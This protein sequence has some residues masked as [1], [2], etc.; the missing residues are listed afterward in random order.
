MSSHFRAGICCG[1]FAGQLVEAQSFLC[2]SLTPASANRVARQLLVPTLYFYDWHLPAWSLDLYS[3]VVTLL[4]AGESSLLYLPEVPDV[5]ALHIFM[6]GVLSYAQD[7]YG[8]L[9]VPSNLKSLQH[10][11]LRLLVASSWLP[12]TSRPHLWSPLLSMRTS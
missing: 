12:S 3:E 2:M 11:I 6:R 9:Q 4:T 7:W 5:R 8:N 1:D 10:W